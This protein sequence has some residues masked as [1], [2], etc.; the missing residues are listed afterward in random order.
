MEIGG[1]PSGSHDSGCLLAGVHVR[2]QRM[3]FHP[4]QPGRGKCAWWW[5]PLGLLM[6]CRQ[7]AGVQPTS[8][9][10]D[11]GTQNW[12]VEN[13]LPQNTVTALYQSPD[14]F[15]WIGTEL[16]LARFD[17]SRFLLLNQTT[18]PNF[19]DA[20]VDALLEI[21][22]GSAP[23]GLAGLWIGTNDGLVR[24][25]DGA[26][27]RLGRSEGLPGTQVHS[28]VGTASDGLWVWTDGGLSRSEDGSRFEP[29]STPAG[30]GEITAIFS[31]QDA[32][33][34]AATHAL[35]RWNSGTWQTVLHSQPTMEVSV[36]A[37]TQKSL[38]VSYGSTLE[39]IE[40]ERAVTVPVDHGALHAG[41][42]HAVEVNG[43]TLAVAGTDWIAILHPPSNHG[44]EHSYRV[45]AQFRCGV[46]LP[47]TRIETVYADHEGGLWIGTNRGLAR[48][49]QGA[50]EQMPERNPIGHE[51]VLSILEDREGSLWLGTETGGLYILRDARF[52]FLDESDGLS[53]AETTAIVED[54]HRALWV[55]TRDGGLNVL[56]PPYSGYGRVMTTRNGLPSDVVLAL[57][58]AADGSVW[59]GTPDG[60]SRVQGQSV[61]TITGGDNL[62]DDFIRSLYVAKN[63]MIWIGTRHGLSCLNPAAK[64]D[65]L[66]RQIHTWTKAD[67]LGSDMIGAMAED[68]SGDLWIATFHGLTRLHPSATGCDVQG[69]I[70]NYTQADGLSGDV[71]TALTA[72]GG[73]M[74]VGTQ[75]GGLSLW[76][77]KQ[78][79]GLPVSFRSRLP[80][81]IHGLIADGSGYLWMTSDAGLYR[82]Q[83]DA[84]ANA[85]RSQQ[86]TSLHAIDLEHFT[87]SDGLRSREM[88][89]DSHPTTVETSDGRL[90]F[91]TPRGLVS[92][93]PQQFPAMLSPPPIVMERF[94]VDDV[95]MPMDGGVGRIGAGHLRFEFD[96]AGLS[97][98]MP[99]SV[100]YAYKLEGFDRRWT[101]AGN[102]RNAYYT[103]IPP[104]RYLFRVRAYRGDPQLGGPWTETQIAFQ[105]EPHFYQTIWFY[106]GM[107]VALAALVLLILRWRL[108]LTRQGFEAIMAE[109]NRIA[110]EIHDTLAQGYVG[111]SVQLEVLD[112]LVKRQRVEAAAQQLQNLKAL[113]RDGLEDARRSIWAL[114]SHDSREQTLPVR[115][116]RLAEKADK[117]LRTTVDIHG[118]TRVLGPEVEDELLRIAQEAVQNVHK[119]A[120]AQ[121]L[122][123][124]LEYDESTV[125]LTITDDGQGFPARLQGRVPLSPAGHYGLTGMQERAE[126]MGAKMEILSEPGKGTTIRVE[127]ATVT[128]GRTPD[129]SRDVPRSGL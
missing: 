85:M 113:V 68:G 121:H 32:L 30:S 117:A 100:Q 124:R 129:S 63:Q 69:A 43:E 54:S 41:V 29:I 116:K 128:S 31:R 91:S 118:A 58:A 83:A 92:V 25:K 120:R 104:G 105:L 81:T 27:R 79:H 78:F 108:Y 74:W 10:K 99:Q 106:L 15:L 109:R 51:A 115:L 7:M 110:R 36:P 103:N 87:T 61:S 73:R 53:A 123:L 86:E 52:H 1:F 26:A 126:G 28:L 19:P 6:V 44:T 4:L 55:G 11:L 5:I 40:S 77:N 76:Q 94:S 50:M 125:V 60:L 24:W 75:G 96:Y 38:L 65:G 62:P 42:Q 127:L 89:S 45:D 70:R 46:E 21:P 95:S 71:I 14:G 35:L 9:L 17:G 57:A 12:T 23:D 111:V 39:R 98:A 112:E 18:T 88:S 107:V 20:E 90:W 13:G 97:Y 33:W 48:W 67:G 64:T 122:A 93:R 101:F 8:S 82:V 49:Y 22:P 114:R 59:V 2:L 80:A 56:P 37:D 102:R 119:H 47:G 84:I 16:G 3:P 34:V 72:D 66:S